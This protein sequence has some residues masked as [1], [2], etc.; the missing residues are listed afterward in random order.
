MDSINQSTPNTQKR[1]TRLTILCI[2][3]L[4]AIGMTSLYDLML[5]AMKAM[6]EETLKEALEMSKQNMEQMQVGSAEEANIGMIYKMIDNSPF[7]LL[8]NVIELVGVILLMTRKKI[9][10]HFYIASQIGLSYV[11]YIT[12]PEMALMLI[13]MCSLWSLMYWKEAKDL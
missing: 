12:H 9:G 7:H 3:S 2:I 10:I 1:N 8:F 6:P 5:M 4:V 11:A 13:L